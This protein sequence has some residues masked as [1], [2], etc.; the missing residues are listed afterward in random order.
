MLRGVL[1]ISF[2]LS[3]PFCLLGQQ[4]PNSHLK[5]VAP[6]APLF[7]SLRR[8]DVSGSLEFSS[9]RCDPE[10]P[11]E[12][13][14]WR[15][16]GASEGSPLQVAR[17]TFA[18]DPTVQ[19]TQDADGIR[20][21]QSGVPTDLL[22]LRIT[23]VPHFLAY[24]AN[25]AKQSILW[26]SETAAFMRAHHMRMPSGGAVTGGPGSIPPDSH[27]FAPMHDVTVSQAMDRV[28]KTFPGI[29]VYQDCLEADGRGRFVWFSFISSKGPGFYIE[30]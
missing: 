17:E 28:L 4:E 16:L 26:A 5:L 10:T 12:W 29:W 24:D 8:A 19:V 9:P 23:E 15:I 13:P 21:I 25:G 27:S 30:E 20:I 14:H 1:A 11:A 18:D 3:T 2:A 7:E 22:N 6:L